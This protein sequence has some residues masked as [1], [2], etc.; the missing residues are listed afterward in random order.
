MLQFTC[1]NTYCLTALAPRSWQFDPP[2]A[3]IGAGI[4]LLLIGLVYVFR[5]ELR[6]GWESVLSSLAQVRHRLQASA[7]EIYRERL[8]TR[9]RSLITPTHVAPLE[10]LFIEPELLLSSIPSSSQAEGSSL[11]LQRLTLPQAWG[12]HS[13]LAILGETGTGK[14]TLLAHTALLCTSSTEKAEETLSSLQGRL[15][16]YISLPTVGWSE[17][18]IVDDEAE[19]SGEEEE[20]EQDT[21]PESEGIETLIDAA[22]VIAGGKGR[23]VTLLR[24]YLEAG[25]AIVLLDGWDELSS[26]QRQP[27]AMWLDEL[28]TNLPGN[29]WLISAGTR[30][31]APLAEASFVPLTLASWNPRQ[32]E[33]FA[34]QWAEAYTASMGADENGHE[35]TDAEISP[36]L[37]HKLITKL[38]EAARMGVSPLELALRAFVYLADQEAPGR[39]A[40]LFDRAL[41][42]LLWRE[43]EDDA[44][45]L[46]TCRTALGRLALQLQQEG[47][48]ILSDEEIKAEIE[49][50]L[51]PS[52]ERPTNAIL[53]AFHALTGER[54]LLR[55]V[56]PGRYT[57]VHSLWQAY[58]AA[59]Q[60]VTVDPATLVEQ[61]EDP[62]WAETLRFYAELGDMGPLATAWLRR[63]DDMFY[64]RLRVLSSWIGAAPDDAAWR[65][66]AMA[67]LARGFLKSKA[68]AQIRQALANDLA[69][70]GVPGVTYLFKQAL[71]HPDDET[72]AAAVLGLTRAAREKDLPTIEKMLEDDSRAVREAA[73]H[74]LV[75]L[76]INVAMRGL[77]HV[78]MEGDDELRPLAAEKLAQLG[79]PGRAI[80]IEAIDSEDVVVRRA[81]VLG[82]AKL[83]MQEV[84]EKVAREDEQ[85]IVRSAALAALEEDEEEVAGVAPPPEIGQMA[86]LISWA[87]SHG[88][89]VGVGEAS[90]HMI[91]QALSEG[92]TATRLKAA[93]TLIRVGRPDDVEALQASLADPD[94]SVANTALE[95][96]SEVSR[97]YDLKIPSLEKA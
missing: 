42:L 74:G 81:A 35:D 77:E 1:S 20:N 17:P 94:P 62:R 33:R 67:V 89:G 29:L 4:T 7:E 12:E 25:R 30:G 34:K 14:S 63:P 71:Q 32:V 59:R 16:L 92:D 15:P 45:V 19:I 44:W 37:L 55:Q 70:T 27:A 78:M 53:H 83:G 23:F 60:L 31:Y 21:E 75:Y 64:T 26:Q 86:W 79:E 69:T 58:L 39:R 18:E 41:N 13:R 24:K 5:E 2:S 68:P 11:A 3:L 96:L 88:E 80:L 90:R 66:G 93:Q 73:V 36:V 47:Q 28:T 40:A 9:A 72:R 65:D 49:A 51:P 52:E 38:Q 57:F 54:G 43:Q 46:T 87:A 95:A 61:L 48:V 82:L 84:L 8:S 50:A 97:R 6:R 85:W 56:D 10:T 76:N 91:R 22:K